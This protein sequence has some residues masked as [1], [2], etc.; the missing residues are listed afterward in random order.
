[1]NINIKS[2]PVYSMYWS[3]ISPTVIN[4]QRN[5]FESMGINLHQELA[6][7]VSHGRWMDLK[8]STTPD[9]QVIIFCDIDAFPLKK[10]A[11]QDALTFAQ[12]GGVYGLAQTANQL[13]NKNFIYAGPM[14]LAFSKKT[15]RILGEPSF[16][17]TPEHDAGQLLTM[18]AR[19]QN[20]SVLVI[21][22]AAINETAPY[23]E[24]QCS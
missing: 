1:M 8:I 21:N 23:P 13:P 16:R 11:F 19:E 24:I 4:N 12:N 14:F 6:D 20:I 17:S 5:V 15:W 18:V 10:E 9:D 7:G 2:S 3:N 22:P